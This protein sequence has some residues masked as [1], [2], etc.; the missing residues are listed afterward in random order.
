MRMRMED[1]DG[2]WRMRMEDEDEDEDRGWKMEDEDEDEDGGCVYNQPPCVPLAFPAGQALGGNLETGELALGTWHSGIP[3]V[4][5]ESF[6]R[7]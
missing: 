4:N 2:G 5:C 3:Q 6:P 1:E 7:E